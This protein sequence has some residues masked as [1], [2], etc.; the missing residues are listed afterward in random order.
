MAGDIF[1]KERAIVTLTSSGGS[2][3]D[4]TAG[5]ANGTA[6]FDART[7][8]NAPDDMLCTF[9][10]L[11]QWTTITGILSG[12]LV[13]ALYLVPLLDGTNLPDVNTTSGTSAIPPS[14]YVASFSAIAQAVTN[15]NMRFPSNPVPIYNPL[16]YRPYLLNQSGQTMSANWTLRVVSA[17]AQYT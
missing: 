13:A 1:A 2:L 3:A 8:G 16:L 5:V 10:L 9:E 6:D 11:C 7:G 4:L 17:R 12:K 15:T 14:A